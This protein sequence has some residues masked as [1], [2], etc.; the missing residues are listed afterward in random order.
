ML[1]HV[2]YVKEVSDHPNYELALQKAK[3]LQFE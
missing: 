2:E 3:A 1:Q